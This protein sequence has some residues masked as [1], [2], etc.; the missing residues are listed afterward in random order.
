MKLKVFIGLSLL[1]VMFCSCSK[2]EPDSFDPN[3]SDAIEFKDNAV[4]KLCIENFDLDGDN[5]LSYK[6]ASSVASLKNVFRANQNIYYF[7][8][9]KY[10]VGLK[11]L[12]WQFDG[13]ENLREVTIPE[14]VEESPKAFCRCKNLSSV[15]IQD[16]LKGIDGYTFYYSGLQ[17]IVIPASVSYIGGA[18]FLDCDSLKE[19]T[20]LAPLPPENTSSCIGNYA[21]VIYVPSSSVNLYK[22]ADGWRQWS[23]KFRGI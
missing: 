12:G 17:S 1:G 4:A 7:N 5:R 20:I 6:E 21:E 13:C 11:S 18:A 19:V 3:S 2:S 23:N 10:F 22:E 15:T 9:L 8:E 14:N 16:G